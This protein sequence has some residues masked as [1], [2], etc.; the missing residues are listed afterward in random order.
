MDKAATIYAA[1]PQHMQ[2]L[3]LANRVRLAR[4]TLKR[5]IAAGYTGASEVVLESPWEAESMTVSELLMSQRRWGR[6]RCRKFLLSLGLN[7]NKAVGSLTQ[8]QRLLLAAALK[9]KAESGLRHSS[10]S[11]EES[12]A[13]QQPEEALVAA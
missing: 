6:T 2:A 13:S 12:H 7:E 4:A 5:K 3:E 11:D 8:R 10:E 9:A 1:A